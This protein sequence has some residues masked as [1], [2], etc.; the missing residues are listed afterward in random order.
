MTSFCLKIIAIISMFCDHLGYA[1]FGHFSILNLIGRIAF[2]IFAFQISEGYIHT[3]SVVKYLVRLGIFA[4]IS[5]IPFSLFIHKFTNSNPL[6]LNVFF[7]LF[8]GLLSIYIYDYMI[9]LS[10][11][12]KESDESRLTFNNTKIS[13]NTSIKTYI[14][15]GKVLGL[16]TVLL[17]ASIAQLINTDY[18]AWGVILVFMFYL[19]RN[20]KLLKIASFILLVVLKYG[21]QLLQSNFYYIYILICIATL[22]PIFFID[23]YN[24]KQGKKIKY[25][26]YW[27]YPIH[28]L[29]LYIFF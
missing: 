19:F 28:L 1:L 2:P 26:L 3:K 14:F 11:S 21:Q 24:G 18:G 13:K 17:L 15:I 22:L 10:D 12:N 5:Q 7:T 8:L 20:K 16:I 6:S 29:A 23:L 9:K 25:L 4:I 27:F